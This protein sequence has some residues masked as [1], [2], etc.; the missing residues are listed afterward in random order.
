MTLSVD[1]QLAEIRGEL[2]VITTKLEAGDKAAEH[3]FELLKEQLGYFRT[4]LD[5]LKKTLQDVREAARVETTAVRTDLESQIS[6]A[7]ADLIS[8][9]Q[10]KNPHPALEDWL[11]AADKSVASEIGHLRREHDDRIKALEDA[12]RLEEGASDARAPLRAVAWAVVTAVLSSGATSG[13]FLLVQ[14]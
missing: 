4:A 2:G 14:H 13:V 7:M 12:A 5:E 9:I 6:G 10:Q 3:L 8:H 11:R 1:A